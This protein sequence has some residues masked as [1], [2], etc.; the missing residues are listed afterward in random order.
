MLATTTEA[1]EAKAPFS[2]F[3]FALFCAI[4][5]ASIVGIPLYGY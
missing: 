2:P 4:V 1:T 5:A 3:N